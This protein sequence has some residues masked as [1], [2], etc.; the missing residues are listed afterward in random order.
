MNI[1]TKILCTLT[2]AAALLA[3]IG[4]PVAV[5]VWIAAGLGVGL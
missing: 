3:I 1:K 5:G 2:I 4:L